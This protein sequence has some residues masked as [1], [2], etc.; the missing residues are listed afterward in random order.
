[1]T[2]PK[3]IHLRVHSA[4]SLS[5]GAMKVPALLSKTKELGYP[6]I[7]VTDTANMFGAKAFS[8]Y[9]AKDGI[10]PILGCQ[11]Y[12]RNPDADNLLKSKG[13][14][15]EPDKIVLLVKDE[16]GYKNILELM[17]ISYLDNPEPTEKP[18]INIKDI[19]KL[20]K[21]LIALTAG[22]EGQI[23]R[24]LL[25]NRTQEAEAATLKLK[26]IFADRLYMEISRIGTEAEQKTEET[27]IDLAYKH[28]I[29]LVATNEAFFFSP[30]MYEAH[31]ALICIA[32]GE[33]VSNDNRKKYSPNNRLKTQAEMA[34]L[35]Q[36]LPEALNNTVVIAKRCNYLSEFVNPLLPKFDCPDGLT[37]NQYI[38][39]QARQ[40]LEKRMQDHVYFEGMTE[41]EKKDLDE[42][43]FSRLEFELGVIEK[44]GFEGYFLIV[45]DFINWSK[46][47]NIPVGPGRGSGAGSIVA[48][49][50]RITGLDPI[51]WDLLFE[52]FLN[53]DRISMPDFDV[54]FCQDKRGQTIEYVQKK[55]GAD[56]VAQIITYGKLQSKGRRNSSPRSF[57][58]SA[59]ICSGCRSSH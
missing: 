20:N 51:K 25:E 29:P 33:Y 49:S 6:A 4:Y 50:L 13:R 27:F 9:A 3:F 19:E 39:R 16:E 30:D 24:L 8:T 2:D 36:D 15:I 22:P 55:Y 32:A 23:G 46:Q 5:E 56:K 10:K 53:P 26:E 52:R 7:A 47:H 35:F 1:M 54:D 38:K 34:A 11:F 43:Y 28:N 21:G 18:Q 40:G 57:T 58:T 41:A 42:Q 31:D 37:E 59:S 45:A 14:A 12:H 44:M 17:K 48:W